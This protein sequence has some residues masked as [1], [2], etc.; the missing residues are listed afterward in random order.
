MKGLK[1]KCFCGIEHFA[2]PANWAYNDY[3]FTDSFSA[4]I[5]MECGFYT[6]ID[7]GYVPEKY[8]V[9]IQ[10]AELSK[11]ELHEWLEDPR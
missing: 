11:Y 4:S 9:D 8:Y 2:F 3:E 10:P 1:W 5:C 7:W 6:E